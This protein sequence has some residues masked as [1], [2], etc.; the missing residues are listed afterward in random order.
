MFVVGIEIIVQL[1]K[2]K[3]LSE[4]TLNNTRSINHLQNGDL[5][6]TLIEIGWLIFYHF[7][8]QDLIRLGVLALDNLS[9]RSLP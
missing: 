1:Q 9:K 7:D 5:H 4:Y 2:K 3:E 6:H 8:G